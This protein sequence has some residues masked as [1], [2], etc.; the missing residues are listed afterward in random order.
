MNLKAE[1]R[2]NIFIYISFLWHMKECLFEGMFEARNQ[3]YWQGFTTLKPI[4]LDQWITKPKSS[5]I[6]YPIIYSQQAFQGTY[7]Q[8]LK[9]SKSLFIEAYHQTFKIL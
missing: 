3:F 7:V 1:K 8:H 2:E 4:L 5:I 6:H 9:T